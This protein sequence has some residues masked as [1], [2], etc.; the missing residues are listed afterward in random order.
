MHRGTVPE[1]SCGVTLDKN[2][3]EGRDA[4]FELNGRRQN[5]EPTQKG[6]YIHQGKKIIVK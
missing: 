4:F 2:C 1:C 3:Y 5:G 6:V